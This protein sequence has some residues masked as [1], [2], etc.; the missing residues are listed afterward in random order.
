MDTTI[1]W[2]IGNRP[3]NDPMAERRYAH[4]R[5]LREAQGGRPTVTTRIGA[6]L[7]RL[8]LGSAA[9]TSA[10]PNLAALDAVCCTA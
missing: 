3:D 7:A 1:S 10:G 5:A 8:G 4:V 9:A 2:M 6:A